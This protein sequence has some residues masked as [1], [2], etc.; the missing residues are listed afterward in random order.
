MPTFVLIIMYNAHVLP[1][2]QYC[3]PI[4]CNTYQTHLLPLIRLQKKIIR[5]VTNSTY[6]E[7]T[8]PLFKATNILKLFDINKLQ[9]AIY[10]Y[11]LLHSG[12]NT[13]LHSQHS[14]PTRT[15]DDLLSPLHNLTIFQHS[16]SFTGP[17]I[18]NLLPT[19]LKHSYTLITFKK[20]YK[21]HIIDRY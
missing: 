5:I 10:M 16:L 7:H 9:I 13:V 1:H 20:S 15:R 12:N 8:H 17:K 14:Y 3:T 11:K 6:Y 4:W 19:E 18:W 21:K 2:L